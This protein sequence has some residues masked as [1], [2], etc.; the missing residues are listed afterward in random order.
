MIKGSMDTL[1][2]FSRI[3][4]KQDLEPKNN[5]KKKHNGVNNKQEKWTDNHKE[6]I[7][8]IKK[9]TISLF[10]MD[11]WMWVLKEFNCIL[12]FI[13]LFKNLERLVFIDVIS[14]ID[15]IKK[16]KKLNPLRIDIIDSLYKIDW[17]ITIKD[18]IF[19]IIDREE[20]LEISKNKSK[21]K[22]KYNLLKWDYMKVAVTNNI[23]IKDKWI[24]FSEPPHFSIKNLQEEA[25]PSYEI[26]NY[27]T[28]MDYESN[29]FLMLIYISNPVEIILPYN[30]LMLVAKFYEY[31][32]VKSVIPNPGIKH[33]TILLDQNT[34]NTKK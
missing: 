18:P 19:V 28:L 17:Y 9:I 23:E 14:I 3:I 11:L 24:S 5:K 32:L 2:D 12:K 7:S 34:L 13:K 6:L 8:R 4:L 16:F 30:K 31:E 33:L 29:D 25:W 26:T 15:V 22:S 20:Q 21:S 10:N 1:K 27:I